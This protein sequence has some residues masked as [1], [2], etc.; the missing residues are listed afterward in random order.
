MRPSLLALSL[1]LLLT[2]SAFAAN[3]A[4]PPGRVGRLAYIDGTVSFHPPGDQAG[5]WVPATLNYPVTTGESFWT[6]ANSKAELQIG[7][8]ELRLDQASQL[9]V[10]R[11]DDRTL[12]MQLDQGDLNLYL[13]QMPQ[14]EVKITTPRGLVVITAPGTYDIDAGQPNGDQ[15]SDQVVI[16]AFQGSARFDPDRGSYN[17]GAN[18]AAIASGQ[19]TEVQLVAA[20]PTDFDNWA[21]SQIQQEAAARQPGYVPA[22]VTGYQDLA[23]YG[24]WAQDPSYGEVWYPNDLP[25]DWAPYRDGHWA[26]VP[27]WGWTWIDDSPWGFAPFHYGRWAYV[28]DRWGW[29]PGDIEA[30]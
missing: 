25:A 24:D 3:A 16:S 22:A 17:I 1:G 29:V 9:D 18:Q 13:P 10:S 28:G 23:R 6:D 8:A 15:P 20:Q 27:P 26:W 4:D 5:D 30:Q 14:G 2:A 21:Q 7:P 19:P 12:D 11:L